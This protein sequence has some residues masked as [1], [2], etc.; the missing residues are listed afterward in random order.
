MHQIFPNT[1]VAK[2]LP[3]RIVDLYVQ[4]MQ[5]MGI[6]KTLWKIIGLKLFIIFFIFKLFF[7]PDMLDR[8]FDTD[9]QKA[10]H[11]CQVLTSTD[12]SVAGNHQQHHL[13]GLRR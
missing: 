11:V 13:P 8:F 10:E 3:A 9:A 12:Q 4:G 5:S 6:G 2:T 7:F 1:K